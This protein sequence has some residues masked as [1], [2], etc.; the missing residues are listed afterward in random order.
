MRAIFNDL[1]TKWSKHFLEILIIMIGIIGAFGLQKW[2]EQRIERESYNV[3]LESLIVD[4]SNDVTELNGLVQISKDLNTTIVKVLNQ[5]EFPSDSLPIIIRQLGFSPAS[6]T[7]NKA[8]FQILE[9]YGSFSLLRLKEVST[10]VQS[11]YNSATKINQESYM[12]QN[13]LMGQKIRP[14]IMNSDLISIDPSQGL[15]VK[16]NVHKAA[17]SINNELSGY[18]KEL[19]IINSILITERLAPLNEKFKDVSNRLK[20][21]KAISS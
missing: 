16:N 21:F 5:Y 8:S 18:L 10:E 19:Y 15:S 9:N 14:L 3:L 7:P 2:N 4:L 6:F 20:T 11:L 1:N 13:R 17:L 12:D